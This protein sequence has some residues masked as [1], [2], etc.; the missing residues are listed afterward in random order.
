HYLHWLS[1]VVLLHNLR[2][3][4]NTAHPNKALAKGICHTSLPR[5][6][7]ETWWCLPSW[8]EIVVGEIMTGVTK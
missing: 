3:L 5:F 4:R 6:S 2:H 8:N 1:E 7:K